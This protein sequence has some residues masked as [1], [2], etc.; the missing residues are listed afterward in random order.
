MES[1][2]E[3][4]NIWH[5]PCCLFLLGIF[6]IKRNYNTNQIIIQ[7]RKRIRPATTNLHNI[8]CPESFSVMHNFFYLVP[9]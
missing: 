3:Y 4:L 6:E 7:P 1:R 9:A 5:T 2:F 8:S